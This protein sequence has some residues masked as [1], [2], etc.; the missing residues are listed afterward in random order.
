MII[1]IRIMNVT[2]IYIHFNDFFR[3]Y[4]LK[5]KG[6]FILLKKLYWLLP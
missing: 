3:T 2:F 4:F 5:R 6:Q 1:D